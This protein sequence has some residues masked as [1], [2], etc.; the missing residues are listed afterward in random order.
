MLYKMAHIEIINSITSI[1]VLTKNTERKYILCLKKTNLSED[2]DH[3][4][5]HPTLSSIFLVQRK[6][7]YT[8]SEAQSLTL[9]DGVS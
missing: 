1:C 2:E 9:K 3:P 7:V 6:K 4:P 5:E 8:P